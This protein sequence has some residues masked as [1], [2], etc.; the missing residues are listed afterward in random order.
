M[1]GEGRVA[2]VNER[3]IGTSWSIQP[4][5]S[6]FHWW[7]IRA[8]P[9]RRVYRPSI[10]CACCW[11][12]ATWASRVTGCKLFGRFQTVSALSLTTI[13]KIDRTLLCVCES[14]EWKLAKISKD[15]PLD[16][17]RSCQILHCVV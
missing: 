17:C 8:A 7:A 6:Y 5:H 11:C 12:G 1:I 15:L 2:R 13:G 9:Q 10:L 4:L 3:V 16:L 14:N